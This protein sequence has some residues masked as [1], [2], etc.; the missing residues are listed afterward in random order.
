MPFGLTN[1]PA[2]FMDLMNHV[3]KPYLEKFV[4][5]FIDD[6][7]IHSKSKEEHEVHL[8]L[9][10]ELI[11]K[12]KLFGKFSK[13]KFWLQDVRFLEHV[14]KNEG[15][16]VDPS[17]TEARSKMIAYASRQ[18]KIHDKNYTTHDLESGAVYF[19][20][21]G[22]DKMYYDL[23]DL[24]LWPKMKKD[25][26]LYVSKCLTCS[27]VKAEHQK[28]SG[29]LLQPDI[30]EWKWKNITMDFVAK[31]PRTSSGHDAIRVI[32]DRLTK[33]A[34]FLAIREDYKTERLA[35]LI[36]AIATESIRNATGF[37]YC[38]P[39]PD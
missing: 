2:V 5:V 16:H 18:L 15:I 29:L 8:K 7:L 24:Y 37:E 26:A 14:V 6:I 31:L 38:L 32:V 3:C 22:A 23:R 35:I 30:L 28:P 19:V 34:Y 33:S 12:E 4:I 11:E 9:M 39:S 25:I 20:H 17:K 27:K 1:T 10:L 21:P 36:L 13:C